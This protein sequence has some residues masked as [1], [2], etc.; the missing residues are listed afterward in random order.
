MSL[1]LSSNELSGPIPP[2]LAQLTKLKTILLE[3]N[4]LTG[5]V[6]QALVELIAKAGGSIILGTNCLSNVSG[7]KSTCK[8]LETT[9]EE[10]VP[11]AADTGYLHPMY[12]PL[13]DV[14]AVSNNNIGEFS[15]A[16]EDAKYFG[17]KEYYYQAFRKYA[18]KRALCM[19][20]HPEFGFTGPY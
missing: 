7:Q 12:K 6:P 8:S 19:A 18:A 17:V 3:S 13:W 10:C 5:S 9:Y 20:A 1:D 14:L 4:Q 15:V 2:A 16:C 11:V